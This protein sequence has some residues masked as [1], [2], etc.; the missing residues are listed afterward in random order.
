M[1]RAEAKYTIRADDKT[2]QGLRSAETRLGRFRQRVSS[3]LRGAFTGLARPIGLITAGLTAW[4]TALGRAAT[5]L[6][7]VAKRAKDLNTDVEEIVELDLAAGLLGLDP[8]RVSRVLERLDRSIGDAAAGSKEAVDAFNQ[9][10]ISADRLGQ[11]DDATDRLAAFADALQSVADPR[12]R[13]D[14]Q[15]TLAGRN[16]G[17]LFAGGGAGIRAGAARAQQLGLTTGLKEETR[18]AERLLDAWTEFTS[19]IGDRV[20]RL[21][22]SDLLASTLETLAEGAS[23]GTRIGVPR[24]TGEPIPG[25]QQEVQL[26]PGEQ[27]L[28]RTANASE[29][30]VQLTRELIVAVRGRRSVDAVFTE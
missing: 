17:R 24:P 4:A 14:I 6:D 20:Q 23:R 18:Q 27:N 19:V 7:D 1:P 22:S 30:Q 10:G 5:A 28:A 15:Q 16:I 2:G 9:L 11:I 12:L 25:L 3:G 29:R 26:Q 21:I 13:S 8:Q